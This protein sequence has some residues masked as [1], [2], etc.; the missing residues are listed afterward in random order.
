MTAAITDARDAQPRIAIFMQDLKGGG[1][2]RAMTNLSIGLTAIGVPVD[3]VMVRRVGPYLGL[4]PSE[5]RLVDLDTGRVS[6]SVPRLASYIRRER[7]A[8]VV[9]PLVHVSTAALIAA[10][11]AGVGTQII[12][13]EQNDVASDRRYTPYGPVRLAFR[14]MPL[15]YRWADHITAVSDGVAASVAAAAWVPRSRVKVLHNP[16][17]SDSLRA[18]AEEPTGHPWLD[19]PGPPVILAAGRFEPQKDY[20]TMVRAFELVRAHRE[21]RLVILG[22]G[23]LKSAIGQMIQ[24]RGLAEYVAMP[25]FAANPYAWM[26][27]CRVFAMSSRWEGLPTVLVEAMACGAT[28]V[29]TRCPSGPEEILANGEFGRLVPMQRP[30]ALAGAIVAS[31]DNP[32][33]PER[34]QK[35]ASDFSVNAIAAQYRDLVCG[36]L[37]ARQ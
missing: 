19:E 29:A 1:A 20:E 13:S 24:E 26:R 5:V 9:T 36:G 7:P 35:R 32:T 34:L 2:E 8:A 27:R 18:A 4:L 12:I 10:R 15:T 33:P 28:V 21:A 6:R 30:E 17:V 16:I 22:E 23:S 11:I 25:G 31:L 3:M 37:R 14:A